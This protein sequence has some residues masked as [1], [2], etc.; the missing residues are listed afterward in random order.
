VVS[1]ASAARTQ[2]R[3][4]RGSGSFPP[5]TGNKEIASTFVVSES[6]FA[7]LGVAPIRGRAFD[8]IN[9][10]ELSALPA[11]RQRTCRRSWTVTYIFFWRSRPRARTGAL[12]LE[13]AAVTD[14]STRGSVVTIINVFTVEPAK[15]DALVTLLTR[16]ADKRR[17][18]TARIH[19][20]QHSPKR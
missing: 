5:T 3:Y 6:Y 10:A 19:L 11:L 4:C 2:E 15:Q 17:F 8:A 9:A 20:G 14:I 7:V 1:R 18:V 16:A 13:E 12:E